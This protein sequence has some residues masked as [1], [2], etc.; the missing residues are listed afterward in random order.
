[1]NNTNSI[2]FS[3]E[4]QTNIVWVFTEG[5]PSIEK[6]VDEYD[7]HLKMAYDPKPLPE[8]AKFKYI[9]HGLGKTFTVSD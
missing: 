1:M 4:S 6:G 5:N 3:P 8:E 7:E 2:N 9:S